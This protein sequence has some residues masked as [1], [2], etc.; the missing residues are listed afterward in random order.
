MLHVGLFLSLALGSKQE[1]LSLKFIFSL[2]LIFPCNRN[3]SQVVSRDFRE[4]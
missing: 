3:L 2:A 1:R 4:V